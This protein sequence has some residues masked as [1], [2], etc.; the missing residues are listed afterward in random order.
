MCIK[1]KRPKMAQYHTRAA[2]LK[3][4]VDAANFTPEQLTIVHRMMRG[5]TMLR[6]GSVITSFFECMLPENMEIRHGAP[7]QTKYGKTF[8]PVFVAL[9]GQESAEPV[10]LIKEDSDEE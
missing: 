9:R 10:D 8:R 6:Q 1:Y 3:P 7:I 2:K 5:C 4:L